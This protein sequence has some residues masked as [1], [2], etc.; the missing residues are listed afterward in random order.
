MRRLQG[1]ALAAEAPD[2]DRS[3]AFPRTSAGKGA[4]VDR[5]LSASCA[6]PLIRMFR[7]GVLALTPFEE[8][9]DTVPD[10]ASDGASAGAQLR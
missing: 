8:D 10:S 1:R 7:G 2:L 6:D 9:G 5:L 4:A 3:E